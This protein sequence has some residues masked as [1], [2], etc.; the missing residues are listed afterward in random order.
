MRISVFWFLLIFS[1]GWAGCKKEDDTYTVG[2]KGGV[3][4]NN[5]LEFTAV[6]P[7]QLDA[8][9]ASL[10]TL[11]VKVDP[12]ATVANRA[13]KF[14]TDG[15]TFLNGDTAEIVTA[16]SE[17][18]A[19]AYLLS[20][21]PRVAHVHVSVLNTYSLD[22]TVT[23]VAALPDDMLLS[24][25]KYAGDT[26]LS[27]VITSSLVRN[28]Q[29]GKVSGHIKVNFSVAPLDTTVNLVYPPFAFSVGSNATITLSNPFQ[30]R[31]RFTITASTLSSTGDS[32]SRNIQIK[33]SN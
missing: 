5:V 15:G 6:S 8:D 19:S 7:A 14:H 26:T 28:T 9:S 2:D 29:R 32:L 33:I 18:Y 12:D 4:L 17:G 16:N 21:S 24:S 11:T 3:A 10:A 23:F 31:G 27:F 1:I 25:N 13:V 22:T 20:D 30:V